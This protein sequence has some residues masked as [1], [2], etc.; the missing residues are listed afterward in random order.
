MDDEEEQRT[1]C[2]TQYSSLVQTLDWMMNIFHFSLPFAV[3]AISTVIIIITIAR[4]GSYSQK[5]KSYKQHL[6]EHL[7][8]SPVILV[9]LP[10]PRLVISFLSGCMGSARQSWLYLIGYYI[11][12]I[13]SIMAF[14]VFVLPSELYKVEF[15]KTMKRVWRR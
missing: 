7:L 12:F 11:S 14:L 5:K 1:W 8:I 10:L 9:A 15:D 4:A 13:P 3:N 2:L 6:H